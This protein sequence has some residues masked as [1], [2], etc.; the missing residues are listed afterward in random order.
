MFVCVCVCRFPHN[1]GGYFV[2]LFVEP[3]AGKNTSPSDKQLWQFKKKTSWLQRSGCVN[4]INR[5]PS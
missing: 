1:L 2:S 5:S 4:L 3:M